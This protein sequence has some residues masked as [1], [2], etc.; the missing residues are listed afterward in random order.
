MQLEYSPVTKQPSPNVQHLIW[1]PIFSL[2]KRM[3]ATHLSCSNFKFV[4]VKYMRYDNI[5][6]KTFSSAV[7]FQLNPDPAIGL[8]MIS[9][10]FNACIKTITNDI[11]SNQQL[12]SAAGK[13]SMGLSF[14]SASRLFLVSMDSCCKDSSMPCCK[15]GHVILKRAT[16]SDSHCCKSYLTLIFSFDF[17]IKFIFNLNFQF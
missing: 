7:H 9:Q 16:I 2:M 17:S 13:I 1:S 10:K 11:K 14:I 5:V 12:L 6:N 8:A 4:I 3:Y 15:D